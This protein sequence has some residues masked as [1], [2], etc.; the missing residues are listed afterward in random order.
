MR[1]REGRLQA[2][3]YM[4]SAKDAVGTGWRD[5]GDTEGGACGS[6]HPLGQAKI[7]S[8]C[9]SRANPGRGIFR[10]L[11]RANEHKPSRNQAGGG[12]CAPPPPA[13][14][15]VEPTR[16]A[17]RRF[18]P[19]CHAAHPTP[20]FIRV[21][22]LLALLSRRKEMPPRWMQAI[23]ASRWENWSLPVWLRSEAG[24][25]G[26]AWLVAP[27]SRRLGTCGEADKCPSSVQYITLLKE[28][29]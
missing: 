24:A 5:P 12:P 22:N 19:S 8:R 23:K 21:F 26:R 11:S 16:G 17:R 29:S 27:V 15:H 10:G 3:E 25:A 9:C 6:A 14:Q 2:C 13:S 28:S 4:P 20:L 1:R 7:H 18:R